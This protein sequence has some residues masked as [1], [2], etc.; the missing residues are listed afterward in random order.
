MRIAKRL[1]KYLTFTPTAEAK[2]TDIALW[3]IET[4]GARQADHY[5]SALL[6]RC[7]DILQGNVHLRTA[8]SFSEQF[9]ETQLMLAKAESHFVV[10]AELGDEC[11]VF[12]FLHE[13]S[14][15][16]QRLQELVDKFSRGN[17]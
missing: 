2:L 14:D 11:V 17:A 10:F 3:T 16:Q 9:P 13:R 15:L 4:F 8:A 5:L 6:D 7:D 12:D 1:A